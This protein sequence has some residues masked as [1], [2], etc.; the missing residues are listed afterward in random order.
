MVT[1]VLPNTLEV[2]LTAESWG[3]LVWEDKIFLLNEFWGKLR[4]CVPLL[5]EGLTT[6]GSSSIDTEINSSKLISVGE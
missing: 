5:L 6:L 1:V 4:E 2:G 3:L